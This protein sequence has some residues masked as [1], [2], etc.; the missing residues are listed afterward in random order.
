MAG[1][2]GSLNFPTTPGALHTPPDGS[3]VFVTK[4]NAAGSAL[5]YPALF[6]GTASDGAGAIDLD[7]GGN[8]WIAGGTTSADYPTTADAF[9]RSANGMAD[10][11]ISQLNAAGT[12]LVYSTLQGGSQSEAGNDIAVDGSGDAYVTGHTYSMDFPVTIGAFDRI[13][14]GDLLIFW[15][16]AFV[17]KVDASAT[18][19]VPPAPPATPGT[20]VLVSPA[21]GETTA[22]PITFDWNVASSAATYTIQIDDSGA[23]TAPMVRQVSLT[24]TMYATTGLAAV[25]HFW[26]VRGVNS[27]GVAGP[28]SV[29]R[30][31]T[32]HEP[33]PAAVIGSLD[34]HPSTVIGGDPSSGTVVLSTGAPD[35]GAVIALSSSDPAVASVP[36]S[37]T[38]PANSFTASFTVSTAAVSASTTVTITASYNG[39]TRS[40]NLTIHPAGSSTST[41]TNF[42]VNPS[43]V[44]GGSNAQGVVVLSAAATTATTVAVS[45]SQP[46]T[47]GVPAS[48]TVQPGSQSAVFV[49]TTSGV[50]AS[51]AVT[52]AATLNGVTKNA[53]LTVTPPS[54][55]PPPPPPPPQTATL[56]V[57]ASGRSGERVTSSPTGINVAT[58]STGSATFAAGTSV[59]LTVSNGRDA[60]WSGACSSGGNKTSSCTFTLNGAASVSANVQ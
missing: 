6:G 38:A 5:V 10:A 16:D 24:D 31:V 21:N 9:D 8:A 45:S 43:S 46:A 40:A 4:F 58:G 18:G 12:A 33:P 55:P 59:R 39:G 51:T 13:W 34:V 25:T 15:G 49:I 50:S 28:W 53:T 57:T 36:A 60:I 47:A 3:D 20:P 2:T 41:L 1:G 42:V 44:T 32:P 35:G 37:T 30:S 17:T 22:Q 14:N 54:P 48:V 19:D 26:R 11:F 56:T 29:V 27:A 23:F 52:I 7:A